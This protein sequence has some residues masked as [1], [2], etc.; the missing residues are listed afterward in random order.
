MRAG[1]DNPIYILPAPKPLP[2]MLPWIKTNKAQN[3]LRAPSL[4]RTKHPQPETTT[5]THEMDKKI[6]AQSRTL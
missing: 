3:M 4:T 5:K 6:S 2:T 1:T